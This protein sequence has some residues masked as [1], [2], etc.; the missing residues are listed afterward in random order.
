MRQLIVVIQRQQPFLL[1][2][3]VLATLSGLGWFLGPTEQSPGQGALPPYVTNGWA[4]TLVVTGAL[5]L[6][7]IGWQ[8]WHFIRG[9]MVLRGSLMMQA[10]AIV[11]YVGFLIGYQA[12]Q[13][14]LSTLAA[15]VW[16][17]ADL[18]E[19]RLLARDLGRVEGAATE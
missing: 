16:V 10:G 1:F 14:Q 9:V 2:F 6:A 4:L 5:G 13:W 12:P 7:G 8:R 11:A 18:A 17:W 15:A 3:L 19:A